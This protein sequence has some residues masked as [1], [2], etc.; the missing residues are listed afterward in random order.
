MITI[1]IERKQNRISTQKINPKLRVNHHLWIF[2]I[3]WECRPVSIVSRRMIH[4]LI[5]LHCVKF[6]RVVQQQKYKWL[7]TMESYIFT[8][9]YIVYTE[10]HLGNI[11]SVFKLHASVR[12]SDKTCSYWIRTKFTYMIVKYR[13]CSNT[14]MN[15]VWCE[16]RYTSYTNTGAHCIALIVARWSTAVFVSS[17]KCTYIVRIVFIY[18]I[19]IFYSLTLTQ[20]DM[21]SRCFNVVYADRIFSLLRDNYC[22]HHIQ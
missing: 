5:Y 2:C 10:Q 20:N 18:Y 3:L 9:M 6:N 7:C 21:D 13:S 8:Y 1:C 12:P 19:Y 4:S 22:G 17:T 11:G 14:N 15:R 16:H